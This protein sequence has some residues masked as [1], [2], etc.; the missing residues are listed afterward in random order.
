[1]LTGPLL[2]DEPVDAGVVCVAAV[3]VGC[4]GWVEVVVLV[5]AAGGAT[6]ATLAVGWRVERLLCLWRLTGLRL[7]GL[8]DPTG[9]VGLA[10]LGVA[11]VTGDGLVERSVR[12]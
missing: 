6:A 9:L 1:M 7:D 4:A 10:L 5:C 2:D 11:G 8:V 3:V 12:L